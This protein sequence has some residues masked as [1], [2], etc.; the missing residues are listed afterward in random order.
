MIGIAWV[1]FLLTL[2]LVLFGGRRESLFCNVLSE[3]RADRPFEESP[4]RCR[5]VFSRVQSRARDEG[6]LSD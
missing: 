5:R 1:V 2:M 6:I 4:S 3:K